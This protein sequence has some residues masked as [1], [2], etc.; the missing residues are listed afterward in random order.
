MKITCIHCMKHFAFCIWLHWTSNAPHLQPLK[1]KRRGWAHT[2]SAFAFTSSLHAI[3][4][5]LWH[6]CW[7]LHK[8][9]RYVWTRPKAS[10][11][12][13]LQFTILETIFVKTTSRTESLEEPLYV[14]VWTWSSH[15]YICWH[16]M[17]NACASLISFSF[18]L[19]FIMYIEFG[20]QII[21]QEGV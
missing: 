9:K 2:W 18:F 13:H 19:R 10:K 1:W 17:F 21:R 5:K 16:N 12:G 3:N 4:V 7:H 14:C 15:M 8:R 20:E 6:Q 11:N